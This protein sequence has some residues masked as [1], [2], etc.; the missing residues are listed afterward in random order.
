MGLHNLMSIYPSIPQNAN[1]D[2]F[3]IF[4]PIEDWELECKCKVVDGEP[5]ICESCKVYFEG[6]Q[7][8]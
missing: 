7:N 5:E 1:K 2:F 3:E 8:E 6:V 4:E